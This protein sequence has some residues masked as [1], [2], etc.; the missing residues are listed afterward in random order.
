MPPPFLVT[1]NQ[2]LTIQTNETAMQVTVE[3]VQYVLQAHKL[4]LPPWN[5]NPEEVHLVALEELETQRRA[6]SPSEIEAITRRLSETSYALALTE[7]LLFGT[8]QI[9]H[10]S[11]PL[12]QPA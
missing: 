10:V 9:P 6:R 12:F 1:V 8:G 5:A 11:T 2:R 3:Q 4:T 7:A